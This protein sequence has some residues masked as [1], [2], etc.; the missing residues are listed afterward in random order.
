[1]PICLDTFSGELSVLGA[2]LVTKVTLEIPKMD[3]KLAIWRYSGTKPYF[4]HLLAS[5]SSAALPSL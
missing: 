5:L 1:M 3:L 2:D 4:R